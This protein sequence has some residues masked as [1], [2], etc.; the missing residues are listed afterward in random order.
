MTRTLWLGAALGL[1]AALALAS[2]PARAA[3]SEAR[4]AAHGL[5]RLQCSRFV[6]LCEKGAEE[7]KLT[8]TWITGYLTAFNALNEDTFDILP[9][10]A[11]ELVAEGAFNLCRR[12][13]D[14]ALVEAVTQLVRVLH[15]QRIEAAADRV[16]IGEGKGAAFLYRATVRELQQRLIDAG[17][18]KGSADGAFG[19]GTKAAVEAFQK[20]AGLEVNGIPDQRTL[21]AL[22]YGAADQQQGQSRD[23]GPQAAR[24]PALGTSAPAAATRQ[25]GAPKLDLNLAPKPN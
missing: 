15:P 4:Y 12:N 9:W 6:E 5:G 13:P 17:H 22:F 10:Q 20:S 8:S 18:L 2:L 24:A 16:R 7:C 23:A 21:I 19:P 3:D 25:P 11:P 1:G 14:A